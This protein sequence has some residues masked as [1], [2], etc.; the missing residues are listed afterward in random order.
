MVRVIYSWQ[1]E[2]ENLQDFIDAWRIATNK[3]HRKVTGAR[4]SFLLQ[5]HTK[6]KEIITI[7]RWDSLEDWK[8]FWEA[9]NPA[10]MSEMHVLGKRVNVESYQ[11]ME[12][13]TF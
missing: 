12:D 8:T 3:I 6:D 2:P 5:N 4:G 1:V 7:A 9:E 13:H 11:E 10:E